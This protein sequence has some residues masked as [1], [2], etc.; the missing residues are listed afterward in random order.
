MKNLYKFA[1]RKQTNNFSGEGGRFPSSLKRKRMKNI[2]DQ[3]LI[4][5]QNKE[6]Q[7]SFKKDLPLPSFCKVM[8]GRSQKCKAMPGLNQIFCKVFLGRDR[9]MWRC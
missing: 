8:S 7:N 2:V 5:C 3:S 9:L 4:N 6:G 1:C